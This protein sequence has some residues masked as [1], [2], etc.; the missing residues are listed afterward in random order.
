MAKVQGLD[1]LKAKIKRLPDETKR[2]M[3]KALNKNADELVA[4]QKRLAPVDDGMLR[5]S[6]QKKPGRH[7]L[8]VTVE[9][10]GAEAFYARWVE[11]G[12]PTAA[13]QQFF[14]PAYRALRKRIKS[15]I[16]RASTKAAKKV[17]GSGK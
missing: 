3:L 9:A 13:A 4:M 1:R 17:A 2:E 14:F 11:F 6:I 10:G 8:A 7:D 12:T 16:T 15:R 5:D